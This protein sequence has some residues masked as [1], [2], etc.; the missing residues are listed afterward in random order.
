MRLSPQALAVDI[1][2]I[3]ELA[4]LADKVPGVY[5]LYFGESDIPTPDFI[6]KAAQ[7]AIQENYTFYTPNAGYLELRQA[8]SQKALE[9]QGLVYDPET[10]VIVTGSGVTALM[11][12]IFTLL[13]R[14]EK[15]IILSPAWPNSKSIVQMVGGIP[16]EVPLVEGR[17]RYLLDLDRVKA[18]IDEKTRLLILS[19]PSNPL[20]WVATVEEQKALAELAYQRGI[21]LLSDEVYER[22]VYNGPAVPSIAKVAPQREGVMIA[23]SFSKSYCMTGWRVGYCLGSKEAIDQMVKLQEFVISHPSS[24]SQRAAI[25][26]LAEGEAFVKGMVERY[27]SQRDLMYSRLIRMKGLEVKKP[28]GAFYVFPRVEGLKDSFEFAKD[29]LLKKAVGVAPGCAFGLGGEGCIRLCFA[30]DHEVIAPA[31]D[32]LEEYL[33]E[34][35]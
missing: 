29:L 14:G 28:E 33:A 27:R 23:H 21:T 35:S 4:V 13:G 8:I 18:S 34:R 15:A 5:K 3:R 16:V 2:R 26:A 9:L 19:S 11:L 7:R 24:V 22:I 10:E 1:S 20:G 30:A 6:K 32:R 25:T 31:L 17:D 12:S